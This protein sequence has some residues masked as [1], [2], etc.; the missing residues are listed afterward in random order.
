[1][2]TPPTLLAIHTSVVMR[3]LIA[4]DDLHHALQTRQLIGQAVGIVMY[5]K[6]RCDPSRMA[7]PLG[8]NTPVGVCQRRRLPVSV[9]KVFL[10]GED[11]PR[12]G[13]RLPPGRSGCGEVRK[14]WSGSWSMSIMRRRPS[15]PSAM[16]PGRVEWGLHGGWRA[17]MWCGPPRPSLR[18]GS[19]RP[20]A[21]FSLCLI[22]SCRCLG[23]DLPAGSVSCYVAAR[24]T[25][26]A[27]SSSVLGSSSR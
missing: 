8:P 26:L 6:L 2:T 7:V 3:K 27:R 12:S 24:N 22:H 19:W 9:G 16:E 20:R 11:C 4:V 10:A 1:V 15:Y 5:P 21:I 13:P 14:S 18:A 25:A 17:G 23:N